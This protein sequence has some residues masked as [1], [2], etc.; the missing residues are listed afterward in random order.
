MVDVGDDPGKE[1]AQG[2]G[3]VIKGG[4]FRGGGHH[5]PL[6]FSHSTCSGHGGG[7]ISA[8][9]TEGRW[10]PEPLFMGLAC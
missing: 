8:L 7:S 10:G 5:G 1:A 3:E 6:Q 4:V 9:S 2:R